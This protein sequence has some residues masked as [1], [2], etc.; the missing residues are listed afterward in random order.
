[1][2]R[3]AA[4]SG[5]PDAL[6]SCHR[7][8]EILP[9]G[10]TQSCHLNGSGLER[11]IQRSA[12]EWRLRSEQQAV[13]CGLPVNQEELVATRPKRGHLRNA[14]P[15][16]PTAQLEPTIRL[17]P[18]SDSRTGTALREAGFEAAQGRLDRCAIFQAAEAHRKTQFRGQLKARRFCFH[19]RRQQR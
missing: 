4:T 1:M 7:Y 5:I 3:Y 10:A 17:V 8:D 15:S 11:Q 18:R 14:D 2:Q 16:L 12:A 9:S 13:R 6:L 19:V